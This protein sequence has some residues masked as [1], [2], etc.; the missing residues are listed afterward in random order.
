MPNAASNI[1]C[2]PITI[3]IP[4]RDRVDPMVSLSRR[5]SGFDGGCSFR[6]VPSSLS[7][8]RESF[9]RPPIEIVRSLHGTDVKLAKSN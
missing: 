5:I 3:R 8:R 7:S 2:M 6:R 1:H 4:R 9:V